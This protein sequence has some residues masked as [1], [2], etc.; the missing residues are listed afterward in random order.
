M[1]AT[2]R[3]GAGPARGGPVQIRRH[4]HRGRSTVASDSSATSPARRGRPAARTRA[5][6]PAPFRGRGECR[7]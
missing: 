4:D 1:V 2:S 5:W 3:V 6:C 7:S